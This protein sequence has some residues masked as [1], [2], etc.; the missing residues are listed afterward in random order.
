[1]CRGPLLNV[2]SH[3]TDTEFYIFLQN[4]VCKTMFNIASA[5]GGSHDP[6]YAIVIG[7]RRVT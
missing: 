4:D 5:T 6:N 1:M 2:V 3:E 7:P